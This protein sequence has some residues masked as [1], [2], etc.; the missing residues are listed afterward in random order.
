MDGCIPTVC[1]STSLYSFKRHAFLSPEEVH[2]MHGFHGYNFQGLSKMQAF[3]LI[4]NGMVSTSV[5]L[6]LL[7]ILRHLGFT[8]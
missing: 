4:G 6:V 8:K 3:N 2:S 5:A 7:P 1:T